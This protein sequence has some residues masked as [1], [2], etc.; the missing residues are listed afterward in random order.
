[1]IAQHVFFWMRIFYQIIFHM[2]SY[3][4]WEYLF[5]FFLNKVMMLSYEEINIL[6]FEVVKEGI[7]GKPE[8]H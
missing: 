6:P 1:M 8:R 3:E 4:I 5:K 7:I 2:F